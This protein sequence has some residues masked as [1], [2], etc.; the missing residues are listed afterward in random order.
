MSLQIYLNYGAL[1]VLGNE[2]ILISCELNEFLNYNKEY[3]W[4]INNE[5]MSNNNEFE[6]IFDFPGEKNI[7]LNLLFNDG[8]GNIYSLDK[9]TIININPFLEPQIDFSWDDDNLTTGVNIRFDSENLTPQRSYGNISKLYIDYYNTGEFDL[10]DIDGDGIKE[11][12][13]IN[14]NTQW[15][16]IFEENADPLEIRLVAVWN[17][18]FEDKEIEI[19]KQIPIISL[20]PDCTLNI[21]HIYNN[22]YFI[23]IQETGDFE[24]LFEVFMKSPIVQTVPCR[25]IADTESELPICSSYNPEGTEYYSIYSTDWIT[26]NEYW[27]SISAP[28][29]YKLKGSIRNAS[30]ETTNEIF[31]EV[32]AENIPGSTIICTRH[33]ITGISKI[34]NYSTS[35]ENLW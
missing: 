28:G 5:F 23:Q 25:N 7:E 29:K 14:I 9:S 11:A 16:N 13:Y 20:P 10:F 2:N 19:I 1:D 12:E 35:G 17:N 27:I 30:G 4:K 6:N 24:Y 8:Y 15:W 33:C 3:E 32:K 21:E 31:F 26:N 22:K 34:Y 18:G